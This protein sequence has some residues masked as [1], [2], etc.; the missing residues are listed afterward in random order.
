MRICFVG[1]ANSSHIVKWCTWFSNH[2]HNVHVI[3]FSLGNIPNTQ[4]HVIDVGVNSKSSDLTKIK[5]LLTSKQIEELI[6]KIKPDI[7]NVHYATSYG[8]AVALS[9]VK[10]YVLSVW[11]SDIYDF[12]K[13]SFLHK[14]LLKYS[15]NK[16]TYLFSTSKAMALEASKYTE[17]EF[18]ITPFGVDMKLFKPGKMKKK[19]VFTIGTVKTMAD[20]YGIDVLIKAI[21]HL[22][23]LYPDD[24]VCVR[25]AGDGPRIEDYKKLVQTL[26]LEKT[27]TFLGRITQ[28]EAAY[29][30]ANMDVGVIPSLQESF[31]VAA[32]EA[33]ACGTPLIIT[34]APGLL[35]TTCPGKSSI[36][37]QIN[38]DKAIC[39][40]IHLLY[41]D[42]EKLTEMGK[43]AREYV[44]NKYDLNKC[45]AKIERLFTEIAIANKH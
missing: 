41:K 8:T 45:F 1:P 3:S 34:T 31:G 42:R 2:G 4:V 7:V 17:K 24:E 9:G 32:V 28:T 33:Q 29:E 21:Y 39:E 26:N 38:D 27:I 23:N 16:A 44:K 37:V 10:N 12:P 22:K 15:L 30:W 25:I 40:A 43:Y 18:L 5:Y 19:S 35:E 6:D 13:K 20:V 36:V 14:A 11:G